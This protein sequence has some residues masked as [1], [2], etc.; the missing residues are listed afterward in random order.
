MLSKKSLE[1]ADRV[2]DWGISNLL[3]VWSLIYTPQFEQAVKLLSTHRIWVI[4]MGKAGALGSKFASSL[5]SN[6]RP[7]AYIHA[8]EM[9]HGDLGAVQRGDVL[10]AISNS[11]RTDEVIRVATKAK[12]IGAKVILLT[13][14]SRTKLAGMADIVL[15]YGKI[16]E[17]CSLHL[18]PTTSILVILAICD[19]LTM[20][21]QV[22]VGTTV[23]QY[24]IYHHAGYLGQTARMLLRRKNKNG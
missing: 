17:A 5:A 15:C 11:G 4:G 18:T 1:A 23:S 8:G 21:V 24:S 9:L 10:V 6:G 13:G 2:F 12:M 7:A 20:A 3:D 14:H 19:A 16:H 22:T